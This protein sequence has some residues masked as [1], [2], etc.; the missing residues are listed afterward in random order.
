MDNK[1]YEFIELL[2]LKEKICIAFSGG[3]DSTF[4]L[5]ASQIA[6]GKNILAITVI[7]SMTPKRDIEGSVNFCRELGIKHI[8]MD[9]NEYDVPEF[10]ANDKD[11]CYF[12]KK[13]IF[14]KVME[15][16][17]KQG[18]NIVADGSNV[19]DDSDYRPGMIALKELGVISPLKESRLTKNDI[20]S[21]SK[22]LELKTWNSPSMA[23]LASRIPYGV[24][25]TKE[26]L[27]MVEL[28]EEFLLSKGFKQFRVRYYDKLARIEVLKDEIPKIISISNEVIGKLKE[29]GF[30][31]ITID[32]EGFRSG[33]MNETLNF[34]GD[35]EDEKR[36]IN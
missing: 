8:L 36:G 11:R 3:V 23:C 1:Y 17:K 33:S 24:E 26:K 13:G 2:K 5:K 19:D 27:K 21:F 10:I 29:I 20:R 30:T 14:T 32:L 35:D 9:A 15:I 22:E 28:S 25:I 18:F 6:L 7:S 34:T 31:Y 12:C 16:A 4:L